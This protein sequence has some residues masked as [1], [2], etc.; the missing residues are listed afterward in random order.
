MAL[1]C[2]P[3]DLCVIIVSE[4]NPKNVGVIVR[5]I[6]LL[7]P[8]EFQVEG[9]F[10][11]PQ[12]APSWLV[13]IA[14]ALLHWEGVRVQRRAYEDSC[15]RPIRPQSDDAIDTHSLRIVEPEAA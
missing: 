2:K 8:S 4:E 14:G 13:E 7:N 9:F 12:T 3:G 11:R 1:R 10:L 15:L 5:C 6:R